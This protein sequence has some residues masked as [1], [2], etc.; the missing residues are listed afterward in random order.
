MKCYAVIMFAI[1]L[2][3]SCDPYFGIN[4][5]GYE[6]KERPLTEAWKEIAYPN[7]KYIVGVETYQSPVQFHKKGGGTCGGFAVALMYELGPGSKMVILSYSTTE[8]LHGVVLYQG[9][10]VDPMWFETYVDWDWCNPKV[11]YVYD[12]SYIMDMATH[13]GMKEIKL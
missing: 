6:V 10:Y 13:S 11:E 1:I 8:A 12:Y 3:W 4:T 5:L 7:H 9:L 2:L